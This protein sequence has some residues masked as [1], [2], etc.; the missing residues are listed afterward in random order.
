MDIAVFEDEI[1]RLDK[2][3]EEIQAKVDQV[4][5]DSKDVIA[6]FEQATEEKN[7]SDAEVEDLVK[8]ANA[9]NS[10]IQQLN[11]EK[12]KSKEANKYYANLYKEIEDKEKALQAKMQAQKVDLEVSVHLF[13][14]IYV[15]IYI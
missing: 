1:E 12:A 7:K 11:Q 2:E 4:K 13:G 5:T 6:S 10:D 9:I 15:G 3:M 14:R 8:E